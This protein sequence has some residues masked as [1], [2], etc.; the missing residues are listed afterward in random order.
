MGQYRKLEALD[1]AKQLSTMLLLC[2][3]EGSDFYEVQT[4]YWIWPNSTDYVER[5]DNQLGRYMFCGTTRKRYCWMAM[6]LF[7]AWNLSTA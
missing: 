5:C 7:Q 6:I 4:S 3:H 2:I 1:Y